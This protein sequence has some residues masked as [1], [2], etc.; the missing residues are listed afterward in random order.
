[1]KMKPE[2]IR[3]A[4]WEDL[5]GQMVGLRFA[6]WDALMSWGPGTTREVADWADM[7]LLMVRPRVTELCQLGFARIT[8]KRGHEGVYEALPYAVAK[9]S[10]EEERAGARQLGLEL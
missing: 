2:D 4:S 8:D 5:M 6:V 7:D 9:R 10:L 1:M 3:N